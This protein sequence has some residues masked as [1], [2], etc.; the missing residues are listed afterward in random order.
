MSIQIFS[1][2]DV[3]TEFHQNLR[4]FVRPAFHLLASM[5]DL[6]TWLLDSA[7]PTNL[8]ARTAST[9]LRKPGH[10]ADA[11]P[12]TGGNIGHNVDDYLRSRASSKSLRFSAVFLDVLRWLSAQR[13]ICLSLE[14][15]Q[16]ADDESA[17][18]LQ[19]IIASHIPVVL[20]LTRRT[21]V[22]MPA[23]MDAIINDTSR[24]ARRTQMELQ[25]LTEEHVA[26]FVEATLHR[27]RS[28]IFPL[29][30]VLAETSGGNPFY[31]R[32]ALELC[33]SK[34]CLW[35]SWEESF[36]TFDLD[37]V[38][39]VFSSQSHG[40][41]FN[42]DFILA[43][44]LDL[45]APSRQL[46]AWASLLG[47]S[48][49]FALVKSL[50]TPSNGQETSS[51]TQTGHGSNPPHPR[52]EL[53]RQSSYDA[54]RALEAAIAAFIVMPGEADETFCFQ[55]KTYQQAAMMLPECKDVQEMHF[56]IARAMLRPELDVPTYVSASY[57]CLGVDVIRR[58]VVRRAPYREILFQAAE[59]ASQSGGKGVSLKYFTNALALLQPEGVRWSDGQEDVDY[60]ETLLLH[61]RIAESCKFS[62][63]DPNGADLIL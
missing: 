61:H 19:A 3:N 22:P 2:T 44:L 16:H 27:E 47:E 62:A 42:S 49:S 34:Q 18:L 30:A 54:V 23:K 28:Y 35:Y 13:L 50:M 60:S 39:T 6:P 58:T 12:T 43:R 37:R 51:D 33:Y 10:G 45:P 11:S 46:I 5:L 40:L 32:E 55:H 4:T 26:A 7:P 14:D 41:R 17:D 38:F 24:R 36:W 52:A 48:F 59:K 21:R 56:S 1:E 8:P 15:V 29:V 20:I 63:T 31:L 9:K 25:P 57:I 53:I